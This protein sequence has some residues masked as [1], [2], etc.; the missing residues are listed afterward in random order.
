MLVLCASI[1]LW[2]ASSAR[3]CFCLFLKTFSKYPESEV[4]KFWNASWR[5][6]PLPDCFQLR[7]EFEDSSLRSCFPVFEAWTSLCSFVGNTSLLVRFKFIGFGFATADPSFKL[8]SCPLFNMA[9][10]FLIGSERKLLNWLQVNIENSM[11]L[12]RR[13]RWFHSSRV[14]LTLVGMS[15]SWFL[16][17]T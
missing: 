14:K 1:H 10:C 6:W 4:C 17:S 5:D 9:L 2:G 8:L 11:M 13:R 3:V 16:V 12:N 7:V 15:A